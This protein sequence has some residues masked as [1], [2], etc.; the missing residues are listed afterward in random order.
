MKIVSFF[1]RPMDI[2][3]VM[4]LTFGKCIRNNLK[5]IGYDGT[6]FTIKELI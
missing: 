4:S 6:V 1:S 2:V 3:I 5:K